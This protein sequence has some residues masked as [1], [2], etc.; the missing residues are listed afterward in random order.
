MRK[1]ICC[2]ILFCIFNGKLLSQFNWKNTGGPFGSGQSFLFSNDKYAFTPENEFLYRTSDG[3]S[4]EKIEHPVSIFMAVYKDTL[5]NVLRNESLDTMRLQLS[6]DNGDNWTVKILPNEFTI[7]DDIV[8]CSSGIYFLQSNKDLL[9]RSQDLGS[10]WDTISSP[11]EIEKLFVFDE[12]VYITSNAKLFRTDQPGDNWENI[13]PPIDPIEYIS[14]VEAH[15]QHI[16]ITTDGLKIDANQNIIETG[17]IWHSDDTGLTWDSKPIITGNGYDIIVRAGNN[18]YADAFDVLLRSSDYGIT[19]D[20]LSTIDPT[21]GVVTLAGLD[22][23]FLFSTSDKGIYSWENTTQSLVQI[24]DGLAKGCIADLSLAGDKIWA[25]CGDGVFNYDL[26]TLTW[27]PK[28]N[29]PVPQ[30]SYDF[31]TTNDH[32]WVA[33]GSIFA[34][35]FYFSENAGATWKTISV[36]DYTDFGI[37]NIELLG[38]N[39]VIQDADVTIRSLDKGLHWDFILGFDFIQT[40][41]IHFKGKY[42]AASQDSIYSSADNGMTW[43]GN[44]SPFHIV[45]LSAYGDDL[46]ALVLGNNATELYISKN[47]IDW[48]FAGDGFPKEYSFDLFAKTHLPIYR[49]ADRYYAFGAGLNGQLYV[50]DVNNIYWTESSTTQYGGSYIFF[51][52]KVYLGGKGMYTTPIENPY[53]TATKEP[54]KTLSISS[55]PNPVKDFLNITINDS[56][57]SGIIHL[58]LYDFKGSL[59]KSQ[60]ENSHNNIRMDVRNIP[61]GIYFLQ[62]ISGNNQT[63]IKVIKD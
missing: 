54:N 47:G 29:L 14:D 31:I 15:D 39:L 46:F 20:T 43:N 8:M 4:W 45:A 40:G 28:M 6:F 59:I 3:L 56:D 34:D 44:S 16:V 21:I 27:S 26:N 48:D 57:I 61:P 2:L 42:F 5:L 12:R 9:F 22:N 1:L 58:N 23:R 33:T 19:W 13:S 63:T 35:E 60:I 51:P 49:D 50:S 18:I 52:D 30:Y 53:V 37:V 41:I 24:N 38:D 7:P 62:A 32:G 10:T 11:V 36:A 55:S 25:G 17:S